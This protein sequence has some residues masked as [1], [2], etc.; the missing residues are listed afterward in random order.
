M[1][2]PAAAQPEGPCFAIGDCIVYHDASLE[3]THEVGAGIMALAGSTSQRFSFSELLNRQRQDATLVSPQG[4]HPS[5]RST[6]RIGQI[7]CFLRDQLGVP[8][9]LIRQ[10][11]RCVRVRLRPVF[12][13]A[14]VPRCQRSACFVLVIGIQFEARLSSSYAKQ[15]V[16]FSARGSARGLSLVIILSQS[17]GSRL[18]QHAAQAVGAA[19]AARGG[20]RCIRRSGGR[21]RCGG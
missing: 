20:A 12:W 9:C 2:V 10:C 21:R 3:S 17:Q 1:F 14:C 6:E 16:C 19:A 5:S 18:R 11:Y 4:E 15:R 8:F 13:G 7:T